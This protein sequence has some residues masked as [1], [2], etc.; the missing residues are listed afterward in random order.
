MSNHSKLSG[1][2]SGSYS[3]HG[4]AHPISLELVQDG[5]RLSGVM[6]DGDTDQET[7]VFEATA[8]AG[9]PP[10]TDERI[11]A[12]LH[13]LFPEADPDAIRY[14]SHLP[15]E[16]TVEGWVRDDSI[17]LLKTYEGAHFGGYK[18][19]DRVL[20]HVVESHSVHYRGKL[21]P[22][23]REIEGHWWI[24]SEGGPGSSRNEGSFLL[25]R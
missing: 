21:S 8:D 11:V 1:R 4:R 9:L 10:G 5:E 16:S 7:T 18:V 24:E 22:D 3:Q 2:W 25:R 20:G 17:Y 19:G 15:A 6:N 13:E 23:G 14:V 12:Q